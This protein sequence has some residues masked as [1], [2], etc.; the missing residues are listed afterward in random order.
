M[1]GTC[2][3]TYVCFVTEVLTICLFIKKMKVTQMFANALMFIFLKKILFIYLRK[4]VHVRESMCRV[5][6]RG[7]AHP[8]LSMEPIVG[9]N[10]GSGGHDLSPRQTLNQLSHPGAPGVYW[11][12]FEDHCI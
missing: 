3:N 5:K 10:P 6:G 11:T 2:Q 7:R 4:R 9:L 1:P 12:E 8:L